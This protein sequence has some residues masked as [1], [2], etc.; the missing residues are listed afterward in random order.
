[1]NHYLYLSCYRLLLLLLFVSEAVP[2]FAKGFGCESELVLFY[3]SES[4]YIKGIDRIIATCLFYFVQ[5]MQTSKLY[6]NPFLQG[7]RLTK[8]PTCQK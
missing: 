5:Y 7:M 6:H 4:M 3:I 1:M 2:D 8:I